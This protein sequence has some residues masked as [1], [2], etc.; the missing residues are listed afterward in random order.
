M[1][2]V[3]NYLNGVQ[4]NPEVVFKK[5]VEFAELEIKFPTS[6]QICDLH[7]VEQAKILF[8]LA[9]TQYRKALEYFSMEKYLSEHVSIK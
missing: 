7:D 6:K 8:R 3:N 5:Y 2:G 4:L 9:N 1:I